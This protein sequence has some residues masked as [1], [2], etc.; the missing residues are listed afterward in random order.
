MGLR[1]M[2]VVACLRSTAACSGLGSRKVAT[3]L[4]SM[5]ACSRPG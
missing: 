1:S 4:Q 5:T 3:C 2:M